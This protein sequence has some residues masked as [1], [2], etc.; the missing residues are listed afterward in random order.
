MVPNP[1]T[2]IA[3]RVRGSAAAARCAARAAPRSSRGRVKRAAGGR[4]RVAIQRKVNGR[5]R[6]VRRATIAVK[7]NGRFARTFR[8][9]RRGRYRVKVRYLG[10]KGTPPPARPRSSASGCRKVLK[11]G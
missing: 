7:A 1:F 4:V 2:R 6:T 11:G 5:F 3:A 10:G 8:R 9:L